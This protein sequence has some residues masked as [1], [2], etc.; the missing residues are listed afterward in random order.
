MEVQRTDAPRIPRDSLE[1][2][3][4]GA[5]QNSSS[6]AGYF[7]RGQIDE[8]AFYNRCLSDADVQNIYNGFG[9]TNSVEE[10]NDITNVS[11]NMV[12]PRITVEFLEPS[13]AP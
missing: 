3:C 12:V 8:V 10:T 7:F 2:V 9:L 5:I 13:V 1:D 6:Q 4:I 11:T